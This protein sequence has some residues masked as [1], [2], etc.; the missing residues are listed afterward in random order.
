MLEGLSLQYASKS[1]IGRPRLVSVT[2]Q[3]PGCCIL[4]LIREQKRPA[5]R[6]E[7]GVE[8]QWRVIF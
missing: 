3:T 7:Y 4:V 8:G 6:A 2:P 1:Q 5:L